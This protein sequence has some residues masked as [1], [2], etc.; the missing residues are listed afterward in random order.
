MEHFRFE[1]RGVGTVL[2]SLSLGVVVGVVEQGRPVLAQE[3]LSW[4]WFIHN[5]HRRHSGL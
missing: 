3:I 5:R 4:L 1:L 2:L